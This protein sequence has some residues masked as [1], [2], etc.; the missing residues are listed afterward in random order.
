MTLQV[1]HDNGAEC[2][3]LWRGEVF[4][5]RFERPVKPLPGR[6]LWGLYG[7]K[8]QPIQRAKSPKTFDFSVLL[9]A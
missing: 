4:A 9:G 2:W 5:G 6:L 8:G 1:Q 7:P 3:L